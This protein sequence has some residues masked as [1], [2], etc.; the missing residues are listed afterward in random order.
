MQQS[1]L[2][3]LFM[4]GFGHVDRGHV[5]GIQTGVIHA[6]AQRTGG[7]VEVLH[8]LGLMPDVAEVFC[9]QY[10]VIQG[11]A[12]MAAHQIGDQIL[13][14][15]QILVDLFVLLHKAVI[16]LPVWLAH[17]GKHIGADMLRR[18]FQLT[19][20]MVLAELAQEGGVFVGHHIVKTDAGTNENL[21]HLGQS[22][23]FLQQLAQFFVADFQFFAGSGVEA[24]AML[25][26]TA[27][28]LLVAGRGA[29]I[30]RGAAHIMDIALEIREGCQQPRFLQQ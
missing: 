20:H 4:G 22:P 24:L 11:A 30:G 15:P 7:G 27:F 29:E 3:G 5:P 8:L 23:H 25:A 19:A 1:P 21:L 18:N 12:G 14:Q 10:R 9:Q 17:L 6:G 2:H 26:G 16:D 28:Q 13:F